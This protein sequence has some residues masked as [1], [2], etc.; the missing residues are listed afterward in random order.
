M[1]GDVLLGGLDRCE[2]LVDLLRLRAEAQ[3]DALAFRFLTTGDVDGGSEEWTFRDL[4]LRA[5][6]I[7]A[8][9]Q[10]A[11]AAA[12][13]ALLLYAPGLDFIAAFMGC[14]YAGVVAVPTYPPNPAQLDRTLPRLRAIARDAG[15]RFV[16][17]TGLI[18]SLSEAL[19]AQAPEL[20]EL[21]WIATDALEPGAASA[22]RAPDISGETLA[23]LQ[24]TSGST[25]HPKGVMVSH[26]N[27]IANE[28]A[29]RAGFEHDAGSSG[30]GWLPLFHDMGLIGNVLQPIFVGFPCTHMS[31]LAF[32]ERPLRWLK[33]ISHFR[34]TTSG[35]PNFAY[36]LCARKATREDLAAL[37]LRSWT[38][39]F[40]GAE[41][42]RA[43]TLDRFAA[44]FAPC[45]FRREAFYPCY[46]L[47][48]A[49]LFASG[50]SATRRPPA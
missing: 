34:A 46:G 49:T 2:T 25:G 13:R 31:P 1:N 45:G 38:V 29:I 6:G 35:G 41:P 10:A 43:E 39:A 33:A 37:D 27:V 48:E 42:I 47:A 21:R 30:V 15:A 22:W 14:V 26:A 16:L 28:R 11:G 7:A 17:T 9:L 32:L 4:H 8:S 36:D 5:M 19:R 20:S 18:A 24:Y 23:F 50:A 3:G 44:V 12:D 40:N